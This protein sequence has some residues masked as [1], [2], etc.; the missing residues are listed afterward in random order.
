MSA[1]HAVYVKVVGAGGAD[2]KSRQLS[3]ELLRF[4]L[5]HKARIVGRGWA[6]KVFGVYPGDLS[7]SKV[8]EALRAR[9]VQRLPALVAGRRVLSGLREIQG[10]Y[11]GLLGPGR[12][13]AQARSARREPE[14][15]AD[16]ALE[17]FFRDEMDITKAEK[18]GDDEAVGDELAGG[19]DMMSSYNSMLKLRNA[20]RKAGREAERDGPPPPRS[21]P[22]PR[23]EDNLP[24]ARESAPGGAPPGAPPASAAP[25]RLPPDDGDEP[26]DPMDARMELARRERGDLEA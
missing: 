2:Q 11:S 21:G 6:L 8:L 23:R 10:F 4:L 13:P 5:A 3:L 16:S 12:P 24:P 1:T 17:G 19:S 25:V 14:P 9:G 15:D 26:E 22:R 7:D 20:G 18:G